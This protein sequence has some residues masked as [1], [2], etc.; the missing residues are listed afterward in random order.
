MD[1]SSINFIYNR[2]KCHAN[3]EAIVWNDTSLP[4]QW[5]LDSIQT[6]LKHPEFQKIPPGA[7]VSIEADFTPQTVAL[8]LALIEKHCIIAPLNRKQNE[9]NQPL[10]DIAQAEFRIVVSEDDTVTIQKTNHNAEHPLIDTLRAKHH[11]GLLLFTSGSS[12]GKKAVLHDFHKFLN[13]FKQTRFA[14]RT[15]PFLR[16]DHIGGINTLFYILSNVGCMISPTNREP[17]STLN[18]IEKH[19]VQLLP[20][21]PT[22]LNMVL[23]SE[24]YKHFSLLSLQLV[25]YGT[26]PMSEHILS[27]F[28]EIYPHIR[29]LQTYGLT[30]VG[31]LR[32]KSKSSESLWVKV[33]G[34]EFQTRVVDGV[35]EV[36][37][38]SAMLGYLNG[39]L[40]FSQDGWFRTGDAVA[41]E[42]DYIRIL[43]RQSEIIHVNGSNVY[44]AQVENVI[45][46]FEGVE[47]ALVYAETTPNPGQR[48]CAKIKLGNKTD[49]KT[50]ETEL[51]HY[52]RNQ[53]K[54]YMIPEKIFVVDH[55]FI[56]ERMKK[57]RV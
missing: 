24:V 27:R 47:E 54:P 1:S 55:S 49:P 15:I 10:I 34:N 32:S 16:F 43:G 57:Q 8:L 18:L 21:T 19:N 4:Y 45:Q 35:L 13:K 36:K 2:F 30:E 12:S 42:G 33:G 11:P 23:Q 5:L 17:E 37:T 20:T 29:L 7:V 50:I 53:L 48:V 6:W 26:E 40:P 14:Y 28:H 3:D 39:P 51:L 25:T 22:F 56:S 41:V 52:C 31:I 9:Q 44:P 38:D 46:T